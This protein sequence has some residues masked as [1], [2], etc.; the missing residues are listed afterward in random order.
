MRHL[1]T[2]PFS[3]LF[4]VR[5]SRESP[6]CYIYN[7]GCFVCLCIMAHVF[8]RIC[9]PP[10]TEGELPSAANGNGRGV[11]LKAGRVGPR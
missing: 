1:P 2:L 7:P 8:G 9:S 4:S 10:F 11:D 3:R 5:G 6:T